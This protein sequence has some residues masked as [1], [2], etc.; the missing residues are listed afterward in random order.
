MSAP[1]RQ[2]PTWAQHK[3]GSI[4]EVGAI[5]PGINK[6]QLQFCGFLLGRRQYSSL[7]PNL[8]AAAAS[9]CPSST[10]ASPSSTGPPASCS[11][12]ALARTFGSDH[13]HCDRARLARETTFLCLGLLP[14]GLR[15][16]LASSGSLGSTRALGRSSL[17]FRCR[18][19]RTGFLRDDLNLHCLFLGRGFR[20][21]S[22]ELDY[23]SL[24]CCAFAR[25]A[26]LRFHD[27]LRPT[28]KHAHTP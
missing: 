24:L 18:A 6:N 7:H 9:S 28:R 25:C 3:L 22:F 12:L 21:S 16:S 23:A 4:P 1:E 20:R 26:G 2:T 17:G 8:D 19:P 13:F 5:T 15:C 14:L 10:T 11:G 27:N